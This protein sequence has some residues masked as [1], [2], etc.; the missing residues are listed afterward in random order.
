MESAKEALRRDP[1][2]LRIS[3]TDVAVLIPQDTRLCDH[4]L[5]H[6]LS[7]ANR[8]ALDSIAARIAA[9]FHWSIEL[10]GA[11]I[12]DTAKNFIAQSLHDSAIAMVDL[13][14][15]KP[16]FEAINWSCLPF[17]SQTA[18]NDVRIFLDLNGRAYTFP[19]LNG[20]TVHLNQ[21]PRAV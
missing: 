5:I 20:A 16:S 8:Q 19:F 2:T 4:C 13:G 18:A 21:S 10:D 14:W 1:G 15:I 11:R 17:S 6:R 7:E 12:R 3:L 9:F